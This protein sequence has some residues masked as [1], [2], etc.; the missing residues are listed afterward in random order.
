M[1]RTLLKLLF[2]GLAALMVGASA[3]AAER[4]KVVYHLVEGI[5]QAARAMAN[6]RNHLRAEPDTQIVVVAHGEGIRFLLKGAQ[7]R[8][9]RPFDSA[10]SELAAQG[11]DFRV[12]HNTL[13]AHRIPESQL[14]PEAKLVPSGVAEVARLQAREGFVYLRP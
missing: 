12:C 7:D 14:V 1:K 11:V 5:D 4:I 13:T 9:N 6:I 2:A 8:N 10:I 3:S